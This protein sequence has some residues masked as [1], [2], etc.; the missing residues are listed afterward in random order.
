M[1]VASLWIGNSLG[2]IE[3]ASIKSFLHHQGQFTLYVYEDVA[4]VPQGVTLLDAR[5]VFDPGEIVKHQKTGSA[6]L[7]S[8]LFR[9]QLL[10]R[11][12]YTW[13]DLDMIAFRKF[14]DA[15][16]IFAPQSEEFYN[17][18]VLKLPKISQ[19]LQALCRYDHNT[20]GMPIAV[21]GFRGLKLKI[22][23]WFLGGIP[24]ARWPWGA[25]GPA[26][27]THFLNQYGETENALPQAAFYHIP[28]WEVRRF[29][30][31]GALTQSDFPP[32]AW[33]VHLWAKE[34]RQVIKNDFG[35]QIP[36]GSYL[37]TLLATK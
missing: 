27:L 20:R 11:T 3:I 8:D 4:N 6:A 24:I 1:P 29:V 16:W 26:G 30:E 35:G 25:L 34:L 14:D 36:E 17:G 7:H 19:T 33:G 13:V 22:R 12:D 18:A 32:E 28:F 23:N 15:D 37:A 21:H 31:P 2:P 9:Y 10:C 5:D